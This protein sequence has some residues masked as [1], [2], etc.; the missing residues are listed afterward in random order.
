MPIYVITATVEKLSPRMSDN[1]LRRPEQ[2][3]DPGFESDHTE[4]S[5]AHFRQAP[6]RL[7]G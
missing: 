4:G 1:D 3:R 6:A 2:S 7:Q 5:W